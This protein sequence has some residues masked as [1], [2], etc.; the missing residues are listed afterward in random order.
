MAINILSYTAQYISLCNAEHTG[1]HM[2]LLWHNFELHFSQNT[3]WRALGLNYVHPLNTWEALGHTVWTIYLQLKNITSERHMITLLEPLLPLWHYVHTS[4][5]ARFDMVQFGENC[6]VNLGR[7]VPNRT[8]LAHSIQP[9]Q[10]GTVQLLSVETAQI[11]NL[12][13][14]RA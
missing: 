11:Y 13:S 14:S 6:N 5:I 2:E 12:S 10:Q 4:T 1:I 8:E 3:T 7:T 9:G